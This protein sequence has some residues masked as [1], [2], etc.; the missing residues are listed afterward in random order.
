[1][2]WKLRSKPNAAGNAMKRVTLI[3]AVVGFGLGGLAVASAFFAW[4]MLSYGRAVATPGHP[5]FA[6][7]QWPY[8]TDEWGKGKAFR[9]EAADCGIEVNLYVRAKIGFC[10]CKTGVSD[11]TELDRLSDFRLMG[12]KPIVLGPGRPINV[13]WMKGRSRAYA[14]ADPYRAP[15]SAL[16]V[17]F[18]DRCD[19]IVATAVVAHDL[20]EAIEP[21]VIDF[22][23]SKVIVHWAEVTLGL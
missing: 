22:L 16:A 21:S 15:N 13:A 8:P 1:M 20:P 10:N 2:I 19:A 6:E 4:P 11:D 14:I 17:A 3:A 7:V 9:C 23:N 18:N 12:E 5:N